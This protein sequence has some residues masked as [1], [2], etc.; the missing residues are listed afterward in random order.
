MKSTL[1][2]HLKEFKKR[3]VP[4]LKKSGIIRSHVFG[5]YARGD[6]R[7]K[8]DIDL[9]V[10]FDSKSKPGIFDLIDIK[11]KLE[12]VFG[13]KVDMM[14]YRSVHPYLVQYINREKVKIL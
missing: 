14:T 1:P 13:R 8:S 12:R 11:E 4:I 2:P 10:H 3:A 7:K 9:L 6:F 5:S